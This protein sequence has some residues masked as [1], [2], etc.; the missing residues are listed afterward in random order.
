MAIQR[1]TCPQH[2]DEDVLGVLSSEGVYMFTCERTDHVSTGTFTWL[3]DPVA[4][5]ESGLG[6]LADTLGLE[7]ELPTALAALGDGWFEYGL[8]EREY[9]VRRPGDFALIVERWSHTAI[10][11]RD[12][13]ASSYIAGTLGQL[14]RVGAVYLRRGTGTGRWKYNSDISYWSIKPDADWESRTTWESVFNDGS[15]DAKEAD[16]ECRAYV[17]PAT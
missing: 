17:L 4:A 6:G 7:V 10:E 15:A 14:A 1:Q 9:A 12:Y 8:V 16:V 3:H 13:S 11:Q 5:A 2:G